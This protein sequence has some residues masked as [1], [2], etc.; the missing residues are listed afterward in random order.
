MNSVERAAPV[1]E[2]DQISV[3]AVTRAIAR[4]RVL[5]C[6]VALAAGV[7]GGVR[8]A[9]RPT[10]FTASALFKPQAQQYQQQ[11]IAGLAS[12]IGLSLPFG[13]T[14]MTPQAYA[15]LAVSS[16][17]LRPV[18]ESQ[19]S[20]R[21]GPQVV[22]G[23]LAELYNP[24]PAPV[25]QKRDATVGLLAKQVATTVSKT[26]AVVLKVKTPH[27]EL[28][29]ELAAR[30]IEE[31]DSLNVRTQQGHATPER[32]F[33][34]QRVAI[35]EAELRQAEGRL[36]AFL[37]S[38]RQFN[39]PQLQLDRDRLNRDV[40]MRQQL[41][42]SLVEA[43]QRARIDEVRNMPAITVLE[44]P[45]LPYA[46]D[47]RRTVSTVV[48]GIALGAVLGLFMA[49]LRD[50]WHRLRRITQADEHDAGHFAGTSDSPTHALSG[51]D[52]RSARA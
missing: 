35:A 9:M 18:A 30:I 33:V 36:A 14:G 21:A 34:E 20:Y 6:G 51:N 42:T 32:E 13:S 41:Y 17:I 19:F 43:Y 3:A 45:E 47:P 39:T 38:N 12:Q 10:T 1:D 2:S 26:G 29:Q 24:G 37:E 49:F 27:P 28:S 50:T 40:T 16:E 46:P 23:T 48:L 52:N 7:A 11:A 22:S 44:S 31:I 8:A 5:I 4:N 25:A 15:D